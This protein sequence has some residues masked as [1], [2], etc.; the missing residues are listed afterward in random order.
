MAAKVRTNSTYVITPPKHEKKDRNT[1]KTIQ[2]IIPKMKTGSYKTHPRRPTL[3]P[4]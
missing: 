3:G 2:K 4:H 1:M